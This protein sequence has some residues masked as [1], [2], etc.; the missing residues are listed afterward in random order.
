MV[1][2]P[3]SS[4]GSSY[5]DNYFDPYLKTQHTQIREQSSMR[6]RGELMELEIENLEPLRPFSFF[7]GDD[8]TMTARSAPPQTT[9]VYNADLSPLTLTNRSQSMIPSPVLDHLLARPRREDS[10]SSLLTS[11]HRSPCNESPLPRTPS[12]SSSHRILVTAV[13]Q[14]PGD[15]SIT[16][17]L[18]NMRNSQSRW[19]AEQ[20]SPLH[21]DELSKSDDECDRASGGRSG[22]I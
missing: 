11:L 5:P 15:S 17:G 2:D 16:G 19:S 8:T 22:L 7:A 10:A 12:G 1:E 4:T 3:P 14:R 20:K 9:T 13:R 21:H 6:R 18:N